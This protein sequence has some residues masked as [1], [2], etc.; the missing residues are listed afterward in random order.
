[1]VVQLLSES[2]KRF[3]ADH[4]FSVA[5]AH[6]FTNG[7]HWMHAQLS[8]AQHTKPFL[9]SKKYSAYGIAKYGICLLAFVA[10]ASIFYTM[11]ILLTP[12]SILVF[13]ALEIHFLFLFPLLIDGVKQPIL[14]SIKAT[15]KIGFWKA[16]FTVL[17][18][19]VYMMCGLLRF[20]NPLRQWYIG[21]LAIIIW[22]Q[23]AVRNRL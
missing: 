14:A 12:L 10:A 5:P 23:Y 6:L 13:Y 7:A 11:H 17:P 16:F 19:G 9:P 21:C 8:D 1:M 2:K 22:Y 18:I 3:L 15:Y 20:S 4:T